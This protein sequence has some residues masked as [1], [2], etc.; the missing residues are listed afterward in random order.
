VSVARQSQ[1]HSTNSPHAPANVLGSEPA[2]CQS[3]SGP[4]HVRAS[5]PRGS[6]RP[7]CWPGPC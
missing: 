1:P 2:V 7:C 4:G 6:T 5:H 3:R